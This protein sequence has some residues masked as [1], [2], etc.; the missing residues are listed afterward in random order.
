MLRRTR[1]E[2]GRELP[3]IIKI[4]H[5]I[6]SDARE[7]ERISGSAG[8]L[9]RI[10]LGRI[11][12]TKERRFTAGGEFD[13]LMRQATGIAK[14]P[15]VA[16]FVTM[17]CE[18]GEKVILCG[19]HRAVYA[20]WEER[21]KKAGLKVA[22]YTGTESPLQKEQ[23][24]QDFLNPNGANVLFLALRSGAGIDGFQDVCSTIVFGEL[25]WSYGV[26]EQL[27]GRLHRDGA[28][29]PVMAYYLISED[30]SDPIVASVLGV[31]KEQIV[32]IQDPNAPLVEILDTGGEDHIKKLAE[33]YLTKSPR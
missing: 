12:S 31:K 24:K 6:E 15:Y 19:H 27:I 4:P 1:A 23:S 16:D 9:A 13:M 33:S 25:D 30:G 10:I 3:P 28:K 22:Y 18:S 2:V 5:T 26:H 14:A 7:I 20:I 21:L 17:L 29:G 11:E 8:E 32:G